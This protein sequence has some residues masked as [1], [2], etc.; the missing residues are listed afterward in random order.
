MSSYLTYRHYRRGKREGRRKS[1][2]SSLVFAREYRVVCGQF[3][4]FKKLLAIDDLHVE[5]RIAHAKERIRGSHTCELADVEMIRRGGEGGRSSQNLLRRSM[6]GMKSTGLLT[7]RVQI[8]QNWIQE[9]RICKRKT[10]GFSE[11]HRARQIAYP[12]AFIDVFKREE[13][14]MR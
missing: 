13:C 4:L 9:K 11:M 12:A 7:L 14:V 10:K 3:V 5:Q 8:T 1:Y 6:I 2:I